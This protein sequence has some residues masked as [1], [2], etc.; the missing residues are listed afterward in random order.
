MN[1]VQVIGREIF[2]SRGIPT[3]ECTLILENGSR[4]SAS[5][6]SGASRGDFEAME[7]RD[8]GLRLMG[9]DKMGL[10]IFLKL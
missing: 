8:G 5:V 7:L 4:V 2:D 10:N 3:I 1:I 6:P 9:K